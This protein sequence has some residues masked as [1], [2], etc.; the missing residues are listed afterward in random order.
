MG[1]V[2]GL[3]PLSHNRIERGDVHRWNIWAGCGGHSIIIPTRNLKLDGSTGIGVQLLLGRH[4]SMGEIIAGGS[5]LAIKVRGTPNDR[6]WLGELR[7]QGYRT[8]W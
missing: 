3:P 8:L 1:N 6:D 2:H 4:D 7:V 5:W